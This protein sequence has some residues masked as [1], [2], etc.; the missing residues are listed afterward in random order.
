MHGTEPYTHVT[1]LFNPTERKNA[2]VEFTFAGYASVFYVRDNHNDIVM[3]GAFGTVGDPSKVKL[4]WQHEAEEP[5]GVI[6]V[7]KEDGYGLYMEA[8]ICTETRRG[9]DAAS[10]LSAG[11]L[12]GLSIGYRTIESDIDD[13]TGARL[14]KKAE[15]WEV[16]IVTFPANE[17][18]GI[19]A[20]TS[21]ARNAT[22]DM[23]KSVREFERFLRDTGYSRA[24]AKRI[25]LSGF[26][27]DEAREEARE[28]R[29]MLRDLAS[30]IYSAA[31]GG[32][33]L[34]A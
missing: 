15:L 6:H 21:G 10:L 23:P 26:G 1:T 8:S 12:S 7:L 25:A 13:A 34:S 31:G 24:E 5:V 17:A 33:A 16:S 11:A 18:A 14:L 22:A 20:I 30:E 4:L 3:P 2:G 28:L 27:R 32:A 29:A 9:A 19:T